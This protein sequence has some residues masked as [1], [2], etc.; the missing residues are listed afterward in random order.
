M[1]KNQSLPQ[2][3]ITILTIFCGFNS[4]S[5]REVTIC[6]VSVGGICRWTITLLIQCNTRYLPLGCRQKETTASLPHKAIV[7]KSNYLGV[8][9]IVAPAIIISRKIPLVNQKSQKSAV[10]IK[11]PRPKARSVLFTL[12][13]W[14][15]L[16]GFWANCR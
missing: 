15:L 3:I 11:R 8:A 12:F 2:N 1:Y 4:I 10:G 5:G 13:L 9:V 16:R 6:C 14:Y 7:F